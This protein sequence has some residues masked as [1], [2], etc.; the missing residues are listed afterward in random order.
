MQISF[1]FDVQV[2]SVLGPLQLSLYRM[3]YDVLEFLLLFLVLYISF[4]T[5]LAKMY[6]YYVAAQLELEKQNMT[7]YEKTHPYAR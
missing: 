6:K 7:H 4:A 3:L 5:G 1:L 2:D